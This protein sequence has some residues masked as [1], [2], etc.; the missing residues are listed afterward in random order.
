MVVNRPSNLAF[1]LPLVVSTFGRSE[2]TH[3]Q[4]GNTIDN[5]DSR[6]CNSAPED[7]GKSMLVR[8]KHMSTLYPS[9]IGDTR[10]TPMTTPLVVIS[11][12]G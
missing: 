10:A 5:G 4:E 8:S 11:D 12:G 9:N 1:L 3:C 7:R 2:E 6:T